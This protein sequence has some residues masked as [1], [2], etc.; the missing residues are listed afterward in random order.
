MSV[1]KEFALAAEL[2]RE[3]SKAKEVKTLTFSSRPITFREVKE[4]I[5][6]L[7]LIPTCVQTLRYEDGVVA[8]STKLE[9]L[10]LQSGDTIQVFY[11]AKGATEVV[12]G[13]VDWLSKCSSCLKELN[14]AHAAGS[15]DT[16]SREYISTFMNGDA[17]TF[18]AEDMFMTEEDSIHDVNCKHFDYLGGIEVIV[19]F[20]KQMMET[21]SRNIRVGVLYL[22]AFEGLCCSALG[23]FCGIEELVGRVIKCGG[24]ESIIKSFLS[25]P[26]DD[27]SL[28]NNCTMVILEALRGIVK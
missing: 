20:L 19:E 17:F 13:A 26:A 11:P 1:A 16:L 24:L 14:E 15:T 21:R 8:D 2:I 28:S 6:G 25:F 7:F 4:E 5:E 9:T 18:L 3:K 23:R 22:E 27:K 10:Y 12:K